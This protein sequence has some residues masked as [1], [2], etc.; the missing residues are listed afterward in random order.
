MRIKE[1]YVAILLLAIVVVWGINTPVMKMVLTVLS[2]NVFLA[3][4]LAFGALLAIAVLF[5][6]KTY[7]PMPL[8]DIRLLA[9][10]GFF[11]FF[12]NQFLVAYGL[13]ATT[14]GNASLVLATL[15]VGVALINRALGLEP[16]SRKTAAGIAVSLLGVVL[17]VAGSNK[18]LSLSGSHVMGAGLIL[19]GQFCYGYYTV[20]FKQLIHKYSV[21]QIVAG[22]ISLC[23]VLFCL[24]ALPELAQIN[25]REISAMAW[26]GIIFSSAFALILGNFIWIWAVGILGSTK[27]SLYQNLC[28]VFS[29]VFAWV[30]MNEAFGLLQA[31]GGGVIFGGLYLTRDTADAV[32]ERAEP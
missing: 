2:P 29:I 23:A 22:I 18:E 15:P 6:T 25:L 19:A 9:S 26:S 27:A 24:I 8:K 11:G 16:L 31:I 21:Y 7:R 12:L 28:P 4:R 1:K 20:F 10:I 5:L 14:A 3:L 32:S 30:F 13:P 17:I